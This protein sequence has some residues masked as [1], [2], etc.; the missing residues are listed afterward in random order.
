MATA[1]TPTTTETAKSTPGRRTLR[2]AGRDKRNAKIATDKAFAKTYFE[3]KSKRATD[4]KSAFRKK[5][6]KK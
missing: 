1:T 6:A 3:T 5:K 4:K 2:K